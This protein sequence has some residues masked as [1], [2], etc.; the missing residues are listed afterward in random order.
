MSW[1]ST[2]ISLERMSSKSRALLTG[3]E[4]R[5]Q[6]LA[7]SYYYKSS[8]H[9]EWYMNPYRPY[10]AHLW[11]MCRHLLGMKFRQ[12]WKSATI[13]ELGRA[14]GRKD[15][16]LTQTGFMIFFLMGKTTILDCTPGVLTVTTW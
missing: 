8:C 6:Y 11:S 10:R 9:S 2:R 15:M 16:R 3:N 12:V 1:A 13:E 7:L 4:L 5:L 14:M